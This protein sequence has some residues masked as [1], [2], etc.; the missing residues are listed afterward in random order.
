MSCIPTP[1]HAHHHA[2]RSSGYTAAGL[3]LLAS[4]NNNPA[5]PKPPH[6]NLQHNAPKPTWQPDAWQEGD[7]PTN[8]SMKSFLVQGT[9]NSP[10]SDMFKVVVP[11]VDG[12]TAPASVKQLGS[13]FAVLGCELPWTA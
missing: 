9:A 2:S 8:P 10:G 11:Q 13:K 4:S 5:H 12:I 3:H 7:L 1:S 6:S